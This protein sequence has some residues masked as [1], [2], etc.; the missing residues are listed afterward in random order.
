MYCGYH[1]MAASLKRPTPGA[2]A[3]KA[4]GKA[5]CFRNDEKSV[6][7]SGTIPPSPALSSV[8]S[9]RLDVDKSPTF[10]FEPYSGYGN[11]MPPEFS[12]GGPSSSDDDA[13]SHAREHFFGG[14]SPTWTFDGWTFAL[15]ATGTKQAEL[16]KLIERHGGRVS[17][18]V[19]KRVHLLVVTDR[20]VQRN[21]QRVRKANAKG[22]ALVL[23]SFVHASLE[24]GEVVGVEEHAPHAAAMRGSRGSGGAVSEPCRSFNWTRA[25]CQRLRSVD[26]GVLRRKRLRRMVLRECYRHQGGLERPADAAAKTAHKAAFRRELHTAREAGRITTDGKLVRVIY[27]V[28]PD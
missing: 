9:V 20:A 26:G 19:H 10:S 28:Q 15:S 25:I 16:R 12:L 7:A 3:F 27:A 18:T 22:I 14:G 11:T 1:G 8:L 13:A 6:A 2:S 24:A 4:S 21:T 23:P 5:G 17:N